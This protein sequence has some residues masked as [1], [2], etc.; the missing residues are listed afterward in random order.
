MVEL[1]AM[2][3][4]LV[5][6][7]CAAVVAGCSAGGGTVYERLGPMLQQQLLTGTA[8]GEP[9]PAP[10]QPREITRA[11]LNQIPYA[12][13]SLQ[14]GDNPRAFVVPLADNGGYLVYQDA[15]RRGIVMRG[16]LI[17]ATHG[18]GYNLD[19]VAHRH[20][21]PIAV[22]TPLPLWP[23]MVERSYDFTIRGQIPYQIAVMCEFDRGV[24]EII[25]IVE[26]RLEVVRMVET[27]TNPERRFVNT[28]WAD[29]ESGFI[30]KSVQWVGPRLDPMTV[31]IIRPYGRS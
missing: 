22:P 17:T 30:W 2:M 24:R 6:L 29:P 12:T 27:C 3:R 18:F 9:E 28:Y 4:P 21:D 15:A 16:G 8:V 19:S 26:L 11:E 23:G 10:E 25:E 1:L 20:D 7:A 13:I 5:M 14:A 31:E